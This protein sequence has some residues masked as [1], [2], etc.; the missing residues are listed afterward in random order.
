LVTR[1]PKSV[2][3]ISTIPEKYF[4]RECRHGGRVKMAV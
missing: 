1:P 3:A 2:Q 4:E